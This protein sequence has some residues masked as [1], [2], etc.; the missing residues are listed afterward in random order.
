MFCSGI[1]N[2]SYD[3][4]GDISFV[5][6]S[7]E[8][9]MIQTISRSFEI[10]YLKMLIDWKNTLNDQQK[11]TIQCLKDQIELYKAVFGGNPQLFISL[12]GNVV[13]NDYN[14]VVKDPPKSKNP[15]PFKPKVTNNENR[16]KSAETSGHRSS[17]EKLF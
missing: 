5:N 13:N 15:L 4:S 6:A 8:G 16:R 10:D 17:H 2:S 7:N 14:D 1:Q 9:T 12:N 3:K 11:D